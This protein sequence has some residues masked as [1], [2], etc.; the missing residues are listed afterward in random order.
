MSSQEYYTKI[1]FAEASELLAQEGCPAKFNLRD[2][3]FSLDEN[4]CN[5]SVLTIEFSGYCANITESATLRML[6]CQL[7]DVLKRNHEHEKV[8]IISLAEH[9]FRERQ[10]KEIDQ[11]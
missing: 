6:I 1:E 11:C 10:K 3:E 4:G 7:G 5:R 9:R 8:H 2:V